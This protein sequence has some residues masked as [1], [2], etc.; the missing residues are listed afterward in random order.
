MKRFW[1]KV[2]KNGPVPA[3]CPEL[4]PCWVWTAARYDRFGYGS[5]SRGTRKDGSVVAHRAAWELTNGAIPG[6]LLVLHKCDVPACVNPSHLFLGTHPD[7]NRDASAKGRSATGARNGARLHPE[8]L[9]R[10]EHNGSAKLAD[11]DVLEIRRLAEHGNSQRSIGRK[12]GISHIHV[13][14]IVSRRVWRHL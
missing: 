13:G 3:H 5:F 4:G 11:L 1:S 8:R 2:D 12:F 14:R 9:A 10:G 7:N 6:Q